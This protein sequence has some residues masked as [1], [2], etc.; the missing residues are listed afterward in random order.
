MIEQIKSPRF[1]VLSLLIM[2]AACTRILPLLIPHIWNF[3]AIG[4]LAIFSGSQF[5]DSRF[6]FIIPM[7]AMLLSDFFLG[8]GFTPIVYLGLMAMVACGIFIRGK[9]NPTRIG[10][11]SLV[12]TLIFYLLTNFVCFYPVSIHPQTLAGAIESYVVALPFLRNM[13]LS[14]LLYGTVL[15]GGFYF[16]EKRYPAL[17]AG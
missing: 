10:L 3:T 9:V 2:L 5:K 11:A 6:S 14:D 8:Q 16:I 1:V 17:V 7:A 4:A 13:L 15:F 12:G